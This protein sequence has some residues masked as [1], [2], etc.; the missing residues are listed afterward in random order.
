MA[1]RTTSR[2]ASNPKLTKELR[3]TTA[4]CAEVLANY[5]AEVTEAL[6]DP[7]TRRELRQLVTDLASLLEVIQGDAKGAA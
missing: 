2:L 1:E 5:E 4:V 6:R 7:M 3:V